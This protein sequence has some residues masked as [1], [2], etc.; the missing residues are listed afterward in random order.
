MAGVKVKIK[1]LPGVARPATKPVYVKDKPDN[2]SLGSWP[3]SSGEVELLESEDL[4]DDGAI[5]KHV[6]GKGREEEKHEESRFSS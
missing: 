2:V 1:N 5:N 6:E 3:K 4:Q